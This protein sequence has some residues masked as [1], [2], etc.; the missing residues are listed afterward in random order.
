M[1]KLFISYRRDDSADVTGRLHD[2]LKGHFGDGTIFLDV[3]T[4]PF[5]MDFRQCI[6]DAVNQCDVLLAVIGDHWLEA[7]YADGPK[8][9]SRRLDDPHDYVRIEVESALARGIPV[10]PLLVGKAVMP[11]EAQLPVALK[12]LAF[13][14]AAQ[15]RPGSDF[16][17]HVDRLIQGLDQLLERN[18]YLRARVDTARH[19][20]SN[21]PKMALRAAREVLDL[22]VRDVYEHRFHEPPGT[23]PLETLIQRMD[24]EGGL[25]GQFD[26]AELVAR[27]SEPA[28]ARW[29]ETLAPADVHQA[30]TQLTEILKWYIEV[31]QP[32]ALGQAPAQRPQ[33]RPAAAQPAQQPHP[34]GFETRIAIIPKGLRSF[35][36]N[37]SDFFLQLLPGPRDKEGLPESIRFW[38]HRIESRDDPS[39]TVGVIYGPSGCGKSSLVKAGLLPRLAG[40]VISVYV[41]ATPGETEARI[42]NLLRK[43]LPALD[44]KLDL[45]DTI[46]ALRHGRGLGPDQKILLVVDQFEQWLHARRG[47][48]ETD[49]VQ[50]LRQC[51]GDHVQC[52]VMVRDDFWV[53]LSR[54]MGGLRIEIL[55]GQNAALVDLFD[56]IHARNVL[57]EFGTAFGRLPERDVALT[58]DQETFLA[59]AI[60]GLAQ[61]GRVIS[62]RLALFAE[63]VKGKPWVAATLKEVGGAQGVGVTFLEE[64]FRSAALRARQKAAQAVL[65]ALLPESGSNIKGNMRSQQELLEASGYANRPEELDALLR[66]LDH[67]LRLITP[68]E[69]EEK[70]EGGRMKDEPG[71]THQEEAGHQPAGHGS[72]SSFILHPS[73]FTRYYQ[74][75]HDYLVHSLREWL[76]RKQ[77][78][79]RRGR[80]ELKLAERSGLWNAKPENR[81]LPT[82]WEWLGIRTLTDPKKWTSP[83]RGMMS[84]ATR[85]HSLRSALALAGLVALI[86]IGVVVRTR[87]ARDREATRI[88]GLVGG[89]VSA[90]PNQVPAIIKELDAKP[91]I[92]ATYLS[93]LLAANAATVD[94][95][96]ARLHARLARVSRDRALVEPLLEELLTSKVGYVAPIRQQ[97]RPYAGEL[98]EKLRAILRDEKAESDRRFRAAMALA[99]Y[100]PES[101]AASWSRQDLKFVA[102]QLVSSNAEFQPLLRDA[103]RPIRARLLGDLERIFADSKATAAQQ[104]SAANAF[105][106]YA[107]GD[108]LKLSQLLALATPE[109]FAVLYQ[110]VAASPAPA[111]IADLARIAATLPPVEL[112]S[113]ERIS[114]GQRRANAAAT[115]L[116]LG[117]REKVLPVFEMT[118]DPEALTQF[119]FRCRPRGVG[120]DALLECLERVSDAPKDRYPKNTRYALLLALGEFSLEE[121]PESRRAA[122]LEQLADWYRHDPSSGVHGAA[123]WLLRQWRQAEVARQVGHTAVPYSADREW[124][125]LAIT[126]KPAAPP[127]PKTEPSK[128]K[129]GPNPEPRKPAESRQS[130]RDETAKPAVSSKSAAPAEKA[131]LEPPAE[132]LPAKTFYYTFIVFPAGASDIGSVN[133]EADRQKRELRHRITLTRP[134]ALLDREVAWE[135]LIAFKPMYAGFMQQSDAKPEDAGAGADWY[136]AV[137]FCRWLG[138][139]SG[140]PEADQPYAAPE[141]LGKAKYP[142]EPNPGAN[143]APRD[144]PLELG[145]RGFRLP[146]ESEWEA[147]SRA[148]AR[149]A[150]GF[151][152]EVS[153]LGR[154]GW[155]AENSGKHVHPP[156]EL[157]PSIRGL[158]DLH[159]NVFEWTH[160]W[161]GEYGVGAVIDPLGAEGGS[162]RVLRGGG[163]S[164]VAAFCRAA[165]RNPHV[166]SDRTSNIGLR[167]ALSPSGISPEAAQGE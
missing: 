164:I 80:A 89:L 9:G 116:R 75:T 24:S 57:L 166:P 106:D 110:I 142:R 165:F 25:P 37:D 107:A 65:K 31:E 47:E 11:A 61:D 85:L 14:H 29:N 149:T 42:Q 154:F 12:E 74:L 91:E 135:E 63:M 51:D 30:L 102:E 81:Y 127:K 49:L 19:N 52:L 122:L 1:S 112:G 16:H 43:K 141:T 26:A 78:E 71:R 23:R 156:R 103:L 55:Q 150:Y 18:R 86:S 162:A 5:G 48:Q 146:T 159:G 46:G 64:T 90:E 96:R 69:V 54:F 155:F 113:V 137:G 84:R 125:T 38:K 111:T 88:E 41:E 120:V 22:V 161:Y 15:V 151:G 139:Q 40:R 3:D 133:D 35:D 50:A 83:Q 145:R 129:A 66:V 67:D 132:P 39:F 131:K 136:D 101:E 77:K 62:I 82:L 148:G 28:T 4:I 45:T 70:D 94:A 108:I 92:A 56:L 121:I 7:C 115:L 157:R 95:K 27:L 140:L 58:K 10:V 59:Q 118:D 99:D 105:R 126:V 36:A 167:L 143:W 2:R 60:E 119:L 117:E 13:R 79:T 8:Q 72:D 109:Q 128:E 97:L 163:W 130:K 104:L 73:S 34:A 134:Y 158:F 152:S 160:D 100:V 153:L 87:V 68:T 20:A 93:P 144:W 44:A 6:G 76:T 138:Q 123:G 32:D 147:A 21:N 33:P 53:S 17:G 124:F 98:T 114:Y